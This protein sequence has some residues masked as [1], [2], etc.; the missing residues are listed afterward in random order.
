MERWSITNKKKDRDEALAVDQ[1]N[2]IKNT[3]IK[4]HEA[5]KENDYEKAIEAVNEMKDIP[6]A[7]DA[8]LSILKDFETKE[9][10][11]AFTDP[12]VFDKLEEMLIMGTITNE[13]IDKAYAARDITAKQRSDFKLAKDKKTYIYIQRGRC[14]S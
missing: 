13:D 5:I 2:L 7:S 8:Y 3:N 4:F 1:S 10:G 11:G 12:L 14:I 9:E 6:G